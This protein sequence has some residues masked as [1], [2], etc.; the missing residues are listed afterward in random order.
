MGTLSDRLSVLRRR[1]VIMGDATID[2]MRIKFR[3]Q[4]LGP[5]AGNQWEIATVDHDGRFVK[6]LCDDR[7]Q[8]D[9]IGRQVEEAVKAGRAALKEQAQG[10]A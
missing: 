7:A 9:E 5:M 10:A 2:G 8:W 6:V 3:A 4:F 1:V